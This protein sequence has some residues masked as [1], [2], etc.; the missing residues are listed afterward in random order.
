MGPDR[1]LILDETHQMRLLL[2]TPRSYAPRNIALLS[3]ALLPTDSSTET[4]LARCGADQAAGLARAT[5]GGL[6]HI[7]RDVRDDIH[8]R[9]VRHL[10]HHLG[11]LRPQGCTLLRNPTICIN[12]CNF[13][14]NRVQGHLPHHIAP[15]CETPMQAK[16]TH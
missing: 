16:N 14:T 2:V 7:V 5:H 15:S 12:S 4:C 3:T 1:V 11:R 10:P 6:A 8:A 13:N 9:C